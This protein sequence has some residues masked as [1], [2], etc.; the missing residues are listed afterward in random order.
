MNPALVRRVSG[1]D[2][3]ASILFP[4]NRNHRRVCVAIWLELKYAEDQFARS[5]AHLPSTH[6]FSRRSLEVV[7][8]KLRKMGILKR[9]SHFSPHH[10]HTGGWT[11]SSRFAQ[12]LRKLSATVREFQTPTGRRID[13]QKDQNAIIYV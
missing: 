6:G 13:E 12:C 7:R 2:E 11:F 10:G 3:L 8:A 5:L 1:L 9:V 4:D